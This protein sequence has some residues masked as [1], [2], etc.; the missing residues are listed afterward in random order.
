MTRPEPCQTA[1][2]ERT[3]RRP[4]VVVTG[5]GLNTSLG[6]DRETTWANLRAGKVGACWLD[7]PAGSGRPPF[8]GYP[9]PESHDRRSE[10]VIKA[11]WEAVRDAG[12]F[13]GGAAT[14]D[15]DRAAVVVG[16]SKGDLGRLSRVRTGLAAGHSDAV[17]RTDWERAWPHGMATQLGGLLGLSGPRLAPVAACATG[18]IAVLRAADL[19][20]RGDC[21]VALAGAGDA[22]LEPLPLAAFRNMGVLARV[23]DDPTGAVRPCD[24]HRAGF[25]PGMGSAVLVLEHEEHAR[26]RGVRPYAEVAGGALGADAYHLTGLDPD[27]THLAALIRR[28]LDHAGISTNNLDY[29]NL[30]ATATRDN[31]PL[32]CRAIRQALGD[33]AD[34]VACSANKAQI[35]HLLGAAGAAE[36]AITCLAIR[37][38]FIPP[39]LN[40]T[41]PDPACDLNLNPQVGR[42]RAIRA[43]LKLSLG[44]GGHLAVAVLRQAGNAPGT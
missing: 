22:Q 42:P 23:G 39:T 7:L 38:G 8:A 20:R 10:P 41:D 28:A 11:A 43:A 25:L 9:L 6:L 27:P 1:R 37:D 33:A 40:L 29:V 5:I 18:V 30:H 35:G 14:F 19:I 21:D 17:I 16:Y 32:E 36:L 13:V 26:S 12:L 4:G 15:P 31:D 2:G 34:R 24:R 3:S 44:F